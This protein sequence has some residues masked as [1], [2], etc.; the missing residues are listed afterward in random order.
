MIKV[1]R[2]ADYAV[3]VLATM[4]RGERA[5][6]SA[7]AIAQQSR[8]PEPTVSKVLKA[9]A[10]GDIVTSLRGAGGG[11]RMNGTAAT[12]TVADIIV[13]VDGPIALT[14]CVEKAEES[15]CAHACYCPVRGRWDEVSFA[16]R[17]ALEGVTLADMLKPAS[18]YRDIPKE[19]ATHEHL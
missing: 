11:Y 8:L 12:I 15:S 13:A 18:I 1:S 19:K 6:H 7:T 4:S 14:S 10:K 3:V 17:H 16:I 9:L 5:V 2:L